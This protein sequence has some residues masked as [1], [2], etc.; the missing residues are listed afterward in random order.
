[1]KK[2]IL[3]KP[4][5]IFKFNNYAPL[6]LISVGTSLHKAGFEVQILNC[7][8]EKK[9]LEQIARE[10]EKAFFVGVT[11]L[12]SECSGAFNIMRWIRSCAKVPIVAGGWH[13]TLFP[14][15]MAESDLVDYVVTGE[16]EEAILTVCDDIREH[17]GNRGKVFSGKHIDLDN[18]PMPQ[19]DLDAGIEEFITGSLTDRFVAFLPR[20]PRWLP[21]E[22]SRGCP[23]QCAFCI[24]TVTENNKYRK[25]NARKV[26]DEVT[27]LVKRYGI[28]H[29]KFVD[30]NFFVDINRSRS[31]AEGMIKANVNI[32]WDAECRCDY[33]NDTMINDDALRLFKRAGLVQFTLGIESGS[34]RTL[35]IMK[36][37]I[38]VE[39]AKNAVAKC[40][41]YQIVARSSFMIEV[42]GETYDDIKKT[43]SFVNY[44]RKY[45]YFACGVN[46]F[47]P[48][49][50]CE[51]SEGLLRKGILSEPRS[52]E[53][54]SQKRN[55]ELYTSAEYKRP[56]QV[57]PSYSDN[58]A[59]FLNIESGPRL[60]QHQISGHIQRWINNLF[61]YFA[62]VRNK[63][64]FYSFPLDKHLFKVFFNRFY[65][66][67]EKSK[68][69]L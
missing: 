59:Y 63:F 7:S 14:S 61:I 27:Y 34:Q 45:T 20:P 47:R 40:D 58:A 69:V 23:S 11:L 26:I 38:T 66:A 1:M 3:I 56:W 68:K 28:N 55:M 12:T 62:R 18:L 37:H 17:A 35:D 29:V 46:T 39:Q 10:T 49:P 2:I 4:E 48:Y 32:T 8:R 31:I 6:S 67:Q 52:F 41:A 36:K 42:P 57:C 21:Y 64:E 24:N 54:W 22:S 33:F 51:L 60:A 44:F 50:K 25:K 13:C 65:N 15:Q 16:G 43:V 5:N 9:I 53:E 30:D 19:Y